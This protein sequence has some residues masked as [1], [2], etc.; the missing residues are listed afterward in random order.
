MFKR[1]KAQ[2]TLEYALVIA[3]VIG[4][5]LAINA[6][7][8]KGIQGRLKES[9]DQIGKQF[10]GNGTYNAS[11]NSSS[12]GTTTTTENR[13]EGETTSNVSTGE[14]ITTNGSSAWSE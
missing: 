6:Y 1:N 13:T 3:A 2:S 10:D 7:M 11:W 8:K 9:A 14:T 4:A 5:L 12:S